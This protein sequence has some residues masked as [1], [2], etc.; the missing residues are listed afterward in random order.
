ME[1]ALCVH[2]AGSWLMDAQTRAL[3]L[4]SQMNCNKKNSLQIAVAE[5]GQSA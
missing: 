4:H 3:D 5:I 2:G 1:S